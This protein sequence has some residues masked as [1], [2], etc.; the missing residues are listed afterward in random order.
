MYGVELTK[1]QI[2]LV[3]LQE[4][5]KHEALKDPAIFHERGNSFPL[6]GSPICYLR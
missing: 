6:E 3:N 2:E 1:L 4:W 5:I